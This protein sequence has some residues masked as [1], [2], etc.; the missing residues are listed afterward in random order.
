M[1][2]LP[3]ISQ[4]KGP[5]PIS[6]TFN[7]PSDA[8]VCFVVSGSAW[9]QSANQMLGVT[10]ELDGKPIGTAAV[11]SNL[12]SNHRALVPAYIPVTLTFGQHKVSLLQANGST[13]TDLNDMFNVVLQY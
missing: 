10:L 1:A 7:A 3:I 2:I 6:V 9:S 13:V 11:F 5:L 12:Q 8:P 4:A